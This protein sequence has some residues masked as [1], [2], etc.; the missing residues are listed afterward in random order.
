MGRALNDAQ[1]E[2]R[3]MLNLKRETTSKTIGGITDLVVWAPVREGFIHAFENITYETRLKLTAE[4]LHKVRVS[5]REHEVIAPFPDTAERILSLLNFRIGIVDDKLFRLE[6]AADPAN[7]TL[8]LTPRRYM[9]LVATFDGPWEPYMRLIWDP[10]GPFLDLLLCNCVPYGDPVRQPDDD[11]SLDGYR[12]AQETTFEDYADWVRAHQLDPAIFYSTTGLTV[13][14]QIY[15]A[16]L[17]K[18]QRTLDPVPG[19]VAI[20]KLTHDFP[21]ALAAGVRRNHVAETVRLGLEALTVLY[22]LADY[23]P[24]Y[25][26]NNAVTGDGRLLLRASYDLLAGLSTTLSALPAPM[27]QALRQAYAEPLGWFDS[28]SGKP[29]APIG[30]RRLDRGEVQKGILTAYDLPGATITHGALLF[31]QVS[32]AARARDFLKTIAI[33]W[34]DQA[35]PSPDGIFRNIAFTFEG[36]RRLAVSADDLGGFPKEF[37]EGSATRAPMLGDV[38]A[39]HPREW[40]LPQRN[41]PDGLAPIARATCRSISARSISSCNCARHRRHRPAAA[42]ISSIS[43][44]KQARPMRRCSRLGLTW[45]RLTSMPIRSR[46]RNIRSAARSDCSPRAPRNMVSSCSASSPR[47]GSTIRWPRPAAA[48]RHPM[49]ATIS[50]FATG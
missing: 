35:R 1:A 26:P 44:P 20:A 43:A 21:E 28:A 16:K 23:Y 14:D 30:T 34:E 39:N 27:Q 4:A 13:R 17:E 18:T 25:L 7:P 15:L 41:W 10:L 32:D 49:S 11:V 46:R 47:C 33:D 6:A 50:V 42:S 19:D 9:Y 5:A 37:R 22:R 29:P 8:A 24:P 36:L 31:L 3:A 38:G 40:R 2:G 45:R 12:L 48:P